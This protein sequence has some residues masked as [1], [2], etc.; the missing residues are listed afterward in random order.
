M[1]E[2]IKYRPYRLWGYVQD[3]FKLSDAE[4]AAYFGPRPDNP[5]GT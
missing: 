5:D 1:K 2:T 4:M 3:Q